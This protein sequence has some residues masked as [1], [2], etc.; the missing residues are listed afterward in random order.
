MNALVAYD[1][2]DDDSN[3]S[4]SDEETAV[5]TPAIIILPKPKAQI[6]QIDEIEEQDEFLLLK[7]PENLKP[8]KEK[9]KITFPSLSEFKDDEKDELVKDKS[10]IKNPT[11]AN[12]KCGLLGMLP[13]PKTSAPQV[14][15]SALVA[16]ASSSSNTS[17]NKTASLK[18]IPDSVVNRHKP[19]PPKKPIMKA[20]PVVAKEESDDDEEGVSYFNFGSEEKLPEVK[21]SEID[22][23]ISKKVFSLFFVFNR[24]LTKINKI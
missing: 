21:Q 9:I 10:F 3:I 6:P 19:A 7:V 2:S 8:K 18:M 24:N 23:M 22:A 16:A 4:D 20:N 12:R 1:N 17:E 15:L 14:K 13:K 11:A 5:S